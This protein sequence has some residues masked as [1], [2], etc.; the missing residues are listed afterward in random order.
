MTAQYRP[1]LDNVLVEMD[2]APTH[3]RSGLLHI[4]DAHQKNNRLGTVRAVGSGL[5]V[6]VWSKDD[7]LGRHQRRYVERPMPVKTGDRVICAAFGGTELPHDET[8]RLIMFS[9]NEV[10]AVLEGEGEARSVCA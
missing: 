10:Y 1:L 7:A 2:E 8:K 9:M 3:T 4:P 5:S 6:L